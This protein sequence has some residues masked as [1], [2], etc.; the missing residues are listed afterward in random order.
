MRNLVRVPIFPLNWNENEISV[1]REFMIDYDNSK[2]Y[3]K[4][5]DGLSFVDF[6]K[7]TDAHSSNN[8][9]HVT[10]NQKNAWT[11]DILDLEELTNTLVAEKAPLDSPE[12]I[13]V[14]T[15][16]TAET[17]TDTTQ[18]ATAAFV[19]AAIK[20]GDAHSVDGRHVDDNQVTVSYLWTAYKIKAYVDSLLASNDAMIFKGTLGTGGTITVLPTTEYN[21]G[22]SYKV[23][24]A[25]TYAGI[26]CQIG[27]LIICIK[28]YISG[29]AS[30]DDWTVT[31]TNIDGAVTGSSTSVVDGHVAIF[32]GPTGKV[33][34]TGGKSL[35]AGNLVGDTSYGT[36]TIGGSVKSSSSV[37]QVSIGIDGIMT[38][39][40]INA[41]KGGT[42]KT[43]IAANSMLYASA[44]NIYSE[45]VTTTF[46]R[47][48]LAA[49]SGA[50]VDGLNADK[51]DGYDVGLSINGVWPFVPAISG[52][53]TMD[54]GKYIDFHN[55]S[56]WTGV[57]YSYRL[58]TD[59]SQLI[60]DK[61]FKAPEINSSKFNID[62][63]AYI[64]FNSVD[65]T[66]EFVFV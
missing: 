26:V 7:A 12:L 27:D 19:Q 60:G 65:E 54:I 3:A 37:N 35:P 56:D 10:L 14:P 38:V 31:Q 44:A 33:I 34:K 48:L 46:G 57:D 11:Q 24:T 64:Q 18:I 59:G 36:S 40:T 50:L 6:N 20:A 16:P 45:V 1:A 43:S 63:K 4:S 29:T 28:D 52:D 21:A 61:V 51:V 41:T 55:S 23:I 15:A 42:G 32:D 49:I 13:G 58:Y 53:G 25:G 66:I 62:N 9:I 30:I 47:D 5:L 2:L 17:S 39:N 8:D 22:W